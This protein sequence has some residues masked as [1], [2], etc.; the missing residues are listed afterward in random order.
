MTP[1]SDLPLVGS[2]RPRFA[3]ELRAA[4]LVLASL[5]LA[6]CP[7][8]GPEGTTQGE[9]ESETETSAGPE[10]E[11]D[12]HDPLSMPAEPTLAAEDF[13]SAEACATCHPTHYAEWQLSR[14]ARSMRDPVF[15]ALTAIRQ[16]D[17]DGAEDAFCTQCHSAI[18]TRDGECGPGFEFDALSPMALEGIT[19]ESCHKVS[20]VVR[21][22]NA[23]HI[24]DP[25]G[26]M[27]GPIQDPV[28]NTFHT[29][30]Y[31]PHLEDAEF[32]GSCHDVVEI[33]GLNLERPYAEWLESP[34][35]PGSTCQ[36]CHMPTY[37]GVAATGGPM[38]EE[39]HRHRFIGVDLPMEGDVDDAT[40]AEL[41]AEIEALLGEAADLHLALAPSV[42]AGQQLD[43]QLTV[44]NLISGHAFPTGS[45]FLRQA[46]VELEVHDSQDALLYTTG[47]LDSEGD[48]RDF[49]STVSPYGDPDLIVI[50]S[51]L[52]DLH[53]TPELFS[54]RA[55]EHTT[56]AISPLKERT[57][58]LFVPVPEDAV[59]P[60]T[61]SASLH[62][63]A[64]PPFLLRLLGLEP[65]VEL[66]VVRDIASVSAQV[67]LEPAP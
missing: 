41:D 1:P 8:P 23:G 44:E 48:L 49:W 25:S 6:G 16:A 12:F 17:L 59:G 39:L 10:V 57:Y 64:F 35:N 67:E 62:F 66:A 20:E 55:R 60:L 14:H 28:A 43:V 30:E 27:R 40:L 47:G 11:D 26:P 22:Y 63:R 56:T 38:R 29:S 15:R 42:V 3:P 13:T 21:P 65:L 50:N 46:W 7:G 9:S 31:A 5:G 18:C 51:S 32:C 2:S 36:S 24:L 53:G 58:T 37:A 54:W 4:A 33:S 45:T 19:C 61:V 52:S 34:A